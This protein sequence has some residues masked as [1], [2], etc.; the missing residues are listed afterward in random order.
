MTDLMNELINDVAV[1][2]TAPATPGLL[3]IFLPQTIKTEILR[4]CSPPTRYQF[5][6]GVWTKWW[7]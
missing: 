4:K 6:F 2:R 1:Y 7:S 3:D 5:V